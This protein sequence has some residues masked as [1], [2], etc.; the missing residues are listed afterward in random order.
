MWEA[1]AAAGQNSATCEFHASSNCGPTPDFCCQQQKWDVPFQ[2]NFVLIPPAP[3]KMSWT[4]Y[5]GPDNHSS[6]YFP[7][8]AANDAKGDCTTTPWHQDTMKMSKTL[9]NKEL[10]SAPMNAKHLAM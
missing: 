4:N 6:V 1:M 3:S 10:K 2:F 7:C 9:Q 5:T 8:V